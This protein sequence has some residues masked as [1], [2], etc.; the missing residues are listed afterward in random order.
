MGDSGTTPTAALDYCRRLGVILSALS[1][2]WAPFIVEVVSKIRAG[3]SI[4]FVVAAQTGHAPYLTLLREYQ[5]ANFGFAHE[6][7]FGT[8]WL[9][10]TAWKNA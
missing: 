2:S 8:E 4:A 9:V 10:Q 6:V 1:S 7:S 5:L 3:G